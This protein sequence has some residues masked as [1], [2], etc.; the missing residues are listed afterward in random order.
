MGGWDLGPGD[1]GG[2]AGASCGAAVEFGASL[3]L[4]ARIAKRDGS[5]SSPAVPSSSLS[6]S[7]PFGRLGRGEP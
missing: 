2:D 6:C 5:I 1:G 4:A 7:S 3:N